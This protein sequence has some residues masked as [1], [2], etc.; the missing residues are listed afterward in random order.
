[1]SFTAVL[2]SCRC[3]DSTAC[4]GMPEG[5]VSLSESASKRTL[6]GGL[7]AEAGDIEM[8]VLLHP[9]ECISNIHIGPTGV[10]EGD[11]RTQA[12]AACR[13]ARRLQQAHAGLLA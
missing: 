5:L 9:Y 3:R 8:G 7:L 1:M 6:G 2:A 11:H 12:R 4:V 10:H 13:H